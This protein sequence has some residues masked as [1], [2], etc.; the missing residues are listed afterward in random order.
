MNRTWEYITD[1]EALLAA[2]ERMRGETVVGVDTESDSF[3]HYQEKVCLIQITA[4]DRDLIVDPLSIEDLS[5]LGPVFA[6]PGVHKILHGAD[7]DIASLKRDYDFQIAPVFDTMIAAQALGYQRYS[8]ADL[9]AHF[10]DVKL[11]KKYQRQDWSKRPLREEHLE[12][13]RLDSHFLPELFDLLREEIRAAGRGAQVDE[14]CRL[15]E[16]RERPVPTF[17]PNDFLRIKGAGKL[18]DRGKRVLRALYVMRDRMARERDRPHFKVIGNDALLRV[19]A[20]PPKSM[21]GLEKRLGKKHH[22]VR[23]H[24]QVVVEACREGLADRSAVPRS[25]HDPRAL[26]RLSGPD[27]TRH[28]DV[29]RS[30]RNRLAKERGVE[31]GVMMS[32]A[33]LHSIAAA[34]VKK[35]EDLDRI[36]LMRNWQRDEFGEA[37]VELLS[38]DAAR[39]TG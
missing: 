11:D 5:P 8:L 25:R 16:Q 18:D 14:E 35:V 4:G 17:D 26:R 6:D 20:D 12:Y 15:V 37:I 30:W 9:V 22:V 3:F 32:N 2:V 34:H 23:R 10:F 1:D 39:S 36:D 31:A 24:A 21:E 33:V 29:L 38:S 19:A 13:A 27:E 28:F 7:Y